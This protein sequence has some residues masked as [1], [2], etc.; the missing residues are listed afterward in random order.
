MII[1][2]KSIKEKIATGDII[3]KPLED[4]QIQPA[5]VD[6][7]L[8]DEFLIPD[9]ENTLF[10]DMNKEIKYRKIVSESFIVAPK[11][12]VLARTKEYIEVPLNLVAFVEGRSSI[13]RLGLFIQNAGWIDTGFKGTITLELFNACNVPIRLDKDRRICQIVFMK[14]D[15]ELKQGYKGKYLNQ[16]NVTGSEVGKDSELNF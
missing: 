1:S 5:S 2:G 15:K 14:L 8:G 13:G 3:V 16:I 7:R 6:L 9:Q 4:Y 10:I 11:S 12:F